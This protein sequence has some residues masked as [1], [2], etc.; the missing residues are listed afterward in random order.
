MSSCSHRLP[1][2]N[3]QLPLQNRDITVTTSPSIVP[4]LLP[5]SPTITTTTK[6]TVT[7]IT[8]WGGEEWVVN[9]QLCSGMFQPGRV[10]RI[11]GGTPAWS[12]PTP[13]EGQGAE[14]VTLEQ[15]KAQ[16][17]GRHV[18]ARAGIGTQP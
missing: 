4:S 11:R 15:L 8:S 10:W 1:L 6:I 14:E 2:Q 13:S 3:H 7:T 12:S 9:G 5:S 16:H 18:D 17:D